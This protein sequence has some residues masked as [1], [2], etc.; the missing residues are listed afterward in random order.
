MTEAA[1]APDRWEERLTRWPQK[2]LESPEGRRLVTEHDPQMFALVYLSHH[3]RSPETGG[4]TFSEFHLD[5]Y[6][7]AKAWRE[8]S[9]APAEHRDVFI[10]PRSAAKSTMLFLIIPMWL[11]AFGHQRFIAAFADAGPQ[12]RLHVAS[13]KKELETNE[14]LRADFPEL[15][16]P[17]RRPS[18][19]SEADRLDMFMSESGFVI[20]ARGL[21]SASLGMKVGNTRPTMIIVD[22]G[23]PDE[24]NYSQ[25]QKEKRLSTLVD[26]V[27]PLSLS[28]RFVMT[29]TVTMAGSIIHDLVR[30][31]AGHYDAPEW[32][33]DENFRVHHYP[34]L[35]T[36]EAT[37]EQRSLWP[38]KWSL[39][40]LL[41][42]A[43]TRSFAK[44]MQNSPEAADSDYWTRADFRYGLPETP[45]THQLLSIDP[46]VSSKGTSDYTAL[47]V[48]GYAQQAGV[49]V[50]RH[51]RAVK[52]PPGEQLRELV[53]RTID[54]YPDI[55]GILIEANQGGRAWEAILHHMPVTLKLI[56]QHEPKQVRAARLLNH[57][58][59]GRVLHEVPMPIAEEQMVTFPRGANDDVVDA[60][61]AGVQ[62]FLGKKSTAGVKTAA[63]V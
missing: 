54:A 55:T 32:C 34:A 17:A 45:F 52:I 15:C 46:A 38:E 12:A 41:S 39:E 5:V 29:G 10:A 48:I 35:I 60:V 62:V 49:A 50:V 21:D 31:G 51:V 28:A 22:D 19:T 18:G 24:S 6:E 53:L 20:T 56:H 42:V 37:G 8:P 4:V 25:Y 27:M 36:D 43:H 1:A 26:A 11:A 7:Q 59:M 9:T 58:Q 61:G 57:Y 13:F 40:Y 30:Y 3:L 14:R 2:L 16:R 47:A 23:E 33:R 63:Y 44:N